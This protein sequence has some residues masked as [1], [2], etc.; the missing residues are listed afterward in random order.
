MQLN[1]PDKAL[2]VLLHARR[3]NPENSAV[4]HALGE[5]HTR[6]K[7]YQEAFI[8]WQATVRLNSQDAQAFSQLAGICLELKK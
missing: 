6:E 7:R 5:L 1:L 8:E 3:L 2:D 4:H